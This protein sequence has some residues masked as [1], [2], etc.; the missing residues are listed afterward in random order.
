MDAFGWYPF[1]GARAGGGLID[2]EMEQIGRLSNTAISEELI[3][4]G[5]NA[6]VTCLSVTSVDRVVVVYDDTTSA[7]AAAL[8]KVLE[9]L[10]VESHFFN[11]DLSGERP[12]SG[13][14]ARVF[15][16]LS[17]ATVSILAITALQGEYSARR[18]FLD[19]VEGNRTRHAHMPSIT[20]EAFVD[21]LSM[22][23]VEVSAFIDQ[24]SGSGG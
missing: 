1:G 6:I 17:G 5:K 22:D 24:P 19:L 3:A 16:C 7:I 21:A 9:S 10:D 13:F 18:A 20:S 2:R 23:Y 14:P 12:L 8:R 11:I 4:A 15:Q